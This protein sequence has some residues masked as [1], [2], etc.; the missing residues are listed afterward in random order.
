MQGD[1]LP[2]NIPNTHYEQID[3]FTFDLEK[4]I[5]RYK[6]EWDLPMESIVGAMAYVQNEIVTGDY[7]VEFDPGPDFWEED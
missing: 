7:S 2:P 4:L 3:Q 1:E 5:Y 6:K